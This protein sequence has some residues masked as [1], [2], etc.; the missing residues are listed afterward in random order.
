MEREKTGMGQEPGRCGCR[1]GCQPGLGRRDFVKSLAW[2]TAA[3]LASRSG[4]MAGPF[5]AADFEKLVPADKKLDPE[6]VQ[7]L[8]ARGTPSVYRG[9]ELEKIGMPV[10]GI[11]AGQLYLG[12]DGKLW[13]WDIFNQHLRHRRRALRPSA[14]AG[15]APGARLRTEDHGRGQRPRAAARPHGLRPD[16][17]S[18]RVP[19][20]AGR[21]PRSGLARHGV[22]GG[23][24]AV[25]P[26]GRGRLRPAGHRAAVH[27]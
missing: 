14:Q 6:W 4:V 16:H 2:G 7:S 1:C 5:E 10:G 15:L 3:T 21:V 17:V 9:A 19:D 11:C 23:V 18:R 27:A 24:L 8:T 20:R 22:A 25:H 13:H 12:G 26:A